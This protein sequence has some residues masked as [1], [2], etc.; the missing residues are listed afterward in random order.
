MPPIKSIGV[1]VTEFTDM[2]RGNIECFLTPNAANSCSLTTVNCAPVSA[3]H[4]LALAKPAPCFLVNSGGS[5]FNSAY[6]ALSTMTDSSTVGGG[7]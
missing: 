4:F 6:A 5:R 7:I 2:A 1:L 3:V